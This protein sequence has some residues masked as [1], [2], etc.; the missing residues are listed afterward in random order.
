MIIAICMYIQI[1]L[2][3]KLTSVIINDELVYAMTLILMVFNNFE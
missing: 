3:E 2:S 1:A